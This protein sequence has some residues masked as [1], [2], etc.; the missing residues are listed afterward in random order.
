M[1]EPQA[2]ATEETYFGCALSLMSKIRMP[3]QAFSPKPWAG[4]LAQVSSVRGSSMDRK[5]RLPLTEMSFWPPGHSVRLTVTGLVGSLM[6][7]MVK[8]S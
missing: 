2:V 8:P 7:W 4:L 5:S 1:C 6:S 3:S